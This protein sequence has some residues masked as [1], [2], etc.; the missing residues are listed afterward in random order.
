MGWLRSLRSKILGGYILVAA[1]TVAIGMWSAL[2]YVRFSER[3]NAMMTENYRSVVYANGMIA[4][5]DRL[6]EAALPLVLGE[7]GAAEA[8]ASARAAFAESLDLAGGNITVPGESEA[9]AAIESTFSDYET[10][11][12]SLQVAHARGEIDPTGT[13]AAYWRLVSPPFAATRT[14]CLDLFD[15]NDRAMKEVQANLT[16]GSS[17]AVVST[18]L[19]GLAAL[20]MAV[21]LGL[22]VTHV[23]TSPVRRLADLARRVGEGDL[24]VAIDVRSSDEVGVLSREFNAMTERLRQVRAMNVVRLVATQRKMRAAMEAMGDGLVVVDREGNV[25][26]ANALAREV[27]GWSDEESAGRKLPDIVGGVSLSAGAGPGPGAEGVPGGESSPALLEHKGNEGRRFYL[28]ESTRVM[29]GGEDVGRVVLLRDV[30]SLEERG[31]ARSEFMAAISHELR[32]PLTSMVMSIGLLAKNPA[33][34]QKPDDAELLKVLE[35]DSKRLSRLV[36]ELFEVSRLQ[37]GLLYLTFAATDV[38]SMVEFASRPFET[39]ARA[40]KVE[41]RLDIAPDLPP[42][43]ADGDKITWVISNLLG[44]ALRYTP[45]GGIIT[46][47]AVQSGAWIHVSVSDT[48]AGMPP[49]RLGDIFRPYVQL[50]VGPK[51]GAGLGLAISKDMVQAHGGRMWVDSEPGRGSR[52]TFSLPVSEAGTPRP[53]RDEGGTGA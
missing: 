16:A 47:T 41:L 21:V 37:S 2:G 8:T 36:G 29:A 33:F 10:A 40:Q 34:R 39:Q 27:F 9:V 19:A 48:G 13:I 12:V 18:T 28:V 17:R 25:E 24:D 38:A 49:A 52:F 20:L 50:D 22:T 6:G 1:L 5:L 32:T 11:L 44:N 30:T 43:R 46:V 4:A 3:L 45:E 7:A 51:G 35:E 42:V 31:R 53:Q 26:L 14:A 15:L 23:V